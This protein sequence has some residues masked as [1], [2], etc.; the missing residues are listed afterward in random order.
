[1]QQPK[2]E[3]EPLLGAHEDGGHLSVWVQDLIDLH[4][5]LLIDAILAF[6]ISEATGHVVHR[7]EVIVAL[8]L[9]TQTYLVPMVLDL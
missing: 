9:G 5:R 1:M 2:Y 7:R 6:L 4:L 8:P 3:C